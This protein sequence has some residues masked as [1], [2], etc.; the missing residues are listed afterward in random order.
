[1][2]LKGNEAHRDR[3]VLLSLWAASFVFCLAIPF[4]LRGREY[5]DESG[6]RPGLERISGIFAPHLGLML[7][8]YFGSNTTSKQKLARTPFRI[9]VCASVLTNATV[10]VMVAPAL[11]GAA[12]LETS[13]AQASAIAS[14]FSWLV[15][16][17]LGYYFAKHAD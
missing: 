17:A 7:A 14:Q 11:W 6:L 8:Y 16:P 4:V 5:I 13:L 15:A 2:T 1:M 9:A 10:L 3:A 12:A